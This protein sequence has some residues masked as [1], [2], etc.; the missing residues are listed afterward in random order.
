MDPVDGNTNGASPVGINVKSEADATPFH[1]NPSPV[2]DPGSATAS[3]N[4]APD[5]SN[6]SP[7]TDVGASSQ[8][9]NRTPGRLTN[10]LQYLL[11]TVMKAVWKH[12]FAWPFHQPVDA[13]KL[14]LPVS[15]I[16]FIRTCSVYFL[17]FRCYFQDYHKIIRVPMD[18]GTIKRRLE[19]NYYHSAKDCIED[20][21]RMFTNCYVYNKP[22]EDITVMAQTLEKLFLSKIAQMPNEEVE[23]PVQHKRKKP[24]SK[25][26]VV[27]NPLPLPVPSGVISTAVNGQAPDSLPSTPVP[28]PQIPPPAPI[29]VQPPPAQ[30]PTP[31]TTPIDVDSTNTPCPRSLKRKP[32]ESIF[33]PNFDKLNDPDPRSIAPGPVGGTRRESTRPIKRPRKDLPDDQAQ[34]SSKYK[35]EK[36]SEQLKFCQGVVKEL[37]SK[38]HSA[39]GWPFYKPVDAKL[40]G[41]H[42]YHDIIK[43]PMDL[44]T[45]KTKLENREYANAQE[46]AED[47]RLVF[48]NCYRYNPQASEVAVMGHKLQDVFEAK[49]SKMPEEVPTDTESIAPSVTNVSNSELSTGSSDSEQEEEERA[50][51]LVAMAEQLRQLSEQV[52][53]MVN[54]SR[55]KKKRRKNGKK[56]PNTSFKEGSK[57]RKPIHSDVSFLTPIPTSSATPAVHPTPGLP[58]PP[59]ASVPSSTVNTNT[60]AM[61]PLMNSLPSASQT[62][63]KPGTG[64]GGKG[65]RKDKVKRPRQPK[66]PRQPVSKVKNKNATSLFDSDDEDNAKPMSYDEKRQLS[67]DINKLPGDKL[68]RVVHIIQEREPSLRDSNPD[69]IEIDFETLKPSTL[70]E[71]E[72]YVLSCLKKKPRKQWTRKPTGKNKELAEKKKDIEN[73]APADNNKIPTT[74]KSTNKKDAE[75]SRL[76]ESSSSSSESDSSSGSS[77]SSSSDSSD[78]ESGD[79][80]KKSTRV[81]NQVHVSTSGQKITISP[82][83]VNRDPPIKEPTVE[84]TSTTELLKTV[85]PESS[86][87]TIAPKTSSATLSDMLAQPTVVEKQHKSIMASSSSESD[88]EDTTTEG[89]PKGLAALAKMT[90]STDNTK[91]PNIM[92][93]FSRFKKAFKEKKD[94]ENAQKQQEEIRRLQQE[95]LSKER[96]KQMLD[97]KKQAEEEAALEKAV[98]HSSTLQSNSTSNVPSPSNSAIIDREKLREEERRRRKAMTNQIDMSA[99]SDMMAHFEA[100]L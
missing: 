88:D 2:T 47:V 30:A 29:P 26:S 35:R 65:V 68:G 16:L 78:S 76:T 51:K 49:F 83:K 20:F 45:I 96:E 62:E 11:K 13:S 63:T 6:S 66:K 98:A 17:Y 15:F 24:S 99:Q 40:L 31:T 79:A 70:R 37:F 67:L 3:A 48:H 52:I 50:K 14:K 33:D 44:G 19:T 4:R 73:S 100:S 82:N 85:I 94:R 10:Q 38:K 59:I 25:N 95:K 60:V 7:L 81:E 55:E 23:L 69:E 9:T 97:K 74:K 71:L 61:T 46:F 58:A 27:K 1:S 18:L 75:A 22:G 8:Q 64:A 42:D 56:R 39:Y 43:K 91:K 57:A 32:D 77:S 93:D 5:R 84:P 36:L 89:K 54:T 53:K 92:N 34:H 12:Q 72:A 41:L 21:N 28:V 86:N 90:S 80:K 87:G